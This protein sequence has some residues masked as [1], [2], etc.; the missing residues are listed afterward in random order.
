[1]QT[2][3][4]PAE[5]I[6]P[7]PTVHRR[8]GRANTDAVQLRALAVPSLLVICLIGIYPLCYAIY[9]SLRSGSLIASGSFVGAENYRTVLSSSTFWNAAEFTLIFTVAAVVGSYVVGL[10]LALAFQA[11][12]PAAAP[13]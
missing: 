1:M 9:Q 2:A 8:S 5:S 13:A 12:L 10:A 4:R 11:G 7:A 6:Q 3:I